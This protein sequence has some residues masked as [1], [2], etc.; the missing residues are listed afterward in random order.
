[1][2][3]WLKKAFKKDEP[4]AEEYPFRWY[5]ADDAENP[6]NKRVLDIKPFTQTVIAATSDQW[7]AASFSA[8][9]NSDGREF[10]GREI[11]GGTEIE[12]NLVYP[13]NGERLEGI[14]FQAPEMEVKWDIYIYDDCFFFVRSW[15]GELTY[16]A[17][18]EITNDKIIINRVEYSIN[19]ADD[20]YAVNSVHFLLKSHAFGQI[21]PHYVTDLAVDEKTIAH[22][23]FNQFGNKACYA[24]FEEILDATVFGK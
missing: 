19:S 13:H 9:R 11:I 23:S 16:K 21:Y 10:R 6:F 1:M 14:I 24:C 15:T 20:V 3:N 5:A 7:I 2:L 8:N 12:T 4:P 22:F 17:R 18:A